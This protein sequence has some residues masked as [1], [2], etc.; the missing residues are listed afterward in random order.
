MSISV[1]MS[2]FCVC[3]FFYLKNRFPG[4]SGIFANCTADHAIAVLK[5]N[6]D[7]LHQHFSMQLSLSLVVLIPI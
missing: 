5:D 1:V 6:L 7:I 3:V 2:P 4:I